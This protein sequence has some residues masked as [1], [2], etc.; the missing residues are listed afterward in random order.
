MD[1]EHTNGSGYLTRAQI[2]DAGRAKVKTIHGWGGQLRIRQVT[3]AK[4]IELD[5]KYERDRRMAAWIVFSVV[6]EHGGQV[7]MEEDIDAVMTLAA[8]ELV[9]IGREILTFNGIGEDAE[10]A[11]L[12]NSEPQATASTSV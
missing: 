5:E 9:R 3:G 1:P 10:K 8:G 6:D 4:S 12:K 2:L 7:F 11:I